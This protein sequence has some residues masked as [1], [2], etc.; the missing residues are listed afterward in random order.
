MRTNNGWLILLC[1][2]VLTGC[3]KTKILDDVELIMTFGFDWDPTSENYKGTAVAPVYGQNEQSELGENIRYTGEAKTFQD[4]NSF[5]QT[6]A[7]FQVE[8][9]NIVNI[10]FG[11]DLAKKGVEEII[12]G[13]NEIPDLGRDINVA[14]V[15]GDAET[16]LKTDYRME[17]TLSRFIEKLILNNSKSNIPKMNLHQFNYRLI[18]DGMDPFLPILRQ[19]ETS[20]DIVTLGMMKDDKLV[21]QIPYEQFFTFKLLYEDCEDHTYEFEWEEKNKTVAISSIRSTRSLH[22][23]SKN[24]VVIK[25]DIIGTLTESKKGEIQSF[26]AKKEL[27][28][29]VEKK[30]EEEANQLIQT[31]QDLEIDPLMVGA[32]AR[33]K[34]RDWN[35]KEWE[36]QYPEITITPDISFEL[37]LSNIVQ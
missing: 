19:S 14:I 16:L 1:C 21:H 20:I 17:L 7:P 13:I 6:E 3:V 29:A 12:Y 2:L 4:I 26:A 23:K 11:E 18:G 10:V 27:E 33:S 35:R 31:F 28:Q 32:S 34:F 36:S 8:V 24:E 25:A 5:I 9:G 15:Q 22:W 30:L 37:D